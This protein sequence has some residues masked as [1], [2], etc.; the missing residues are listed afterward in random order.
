MEEQKL[1]ASNSVTMDISMIVFMALSVPFP[2]LSWLLFLH[3]P[4]PMAPLPPSSSSCI[5]ILLSLLSP[6]L[7][8]N[9]LKANYYITVLYIIILL[10]YSSVSA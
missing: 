1:L 4:L 6:L 9:N 2:V 10:L 8:V 5:S 3:L 7:S